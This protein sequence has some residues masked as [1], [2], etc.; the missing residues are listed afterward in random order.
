MIVLHT[1]NKEQIIAIHHM[2]E[3]NVSFCFAMSPNVIHSFKI[4]F[5]VNSHKHNEAQR[6]KKTHISQ[7]QMGEEHLRSHQS[8]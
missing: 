1:K 2:H 5:G 6:N 3:S 8:F 4:Y 7:L